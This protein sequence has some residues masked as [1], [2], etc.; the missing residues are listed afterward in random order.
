MPL[1]YSP[2]VR[3]NGNKVIESDVRSSFA[4]TVRWWRRKLQLTQEQLAERA[5]LHR[6]YISDVE[7]GA[8]NLS[9]E[10]INKLAQAL[11][12]STATL[13]LPEAELHAERG[14]VA[15]R[16]FVEILLVEDNPDDAEL[17][18]SA[19]R[20]VRFANRVHVV[21]DGVEALDFLFCRGLYSARN[22]DERTQLILLDLTLP[23]MDGVETLRRVRGEERTRHI[24]VVVLTASQRE[25]DLTECRRLGVE[26][27][28]GKP[29]SL[30]GLS[31]VTP[32][33]KLDWALV[34]SPSF[35]A[36]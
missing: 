30:A 34:R 36:G 16:Q 14:A 27:Y 32:G 31:E 25:F 21:A 6:T 4:N 23:R 7:R 24:P 18:L 33:L 29:V 15:G 11:E 17:A 10:S 13:F 12:I 35:V 9:L 22:A 19:F 3:T 1:C 28:L 5:N 26:A 20:R 2:C 8:R